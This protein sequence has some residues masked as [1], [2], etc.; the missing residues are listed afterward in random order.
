M[1]AMLGSKFA[2]LF[3][4]TIGSIV[5]LDSRVIAPRRNTIESYSNGIRSRSHMLNAI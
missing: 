3:K 5:M 4:R 1:Q 2:T